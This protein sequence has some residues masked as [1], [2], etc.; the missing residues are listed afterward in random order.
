MSESLGPGTQRTGPFGKW[1]R[2][3]RKT[4]LETKKILPSLC[5]TVAG[6]EQSTS[7]QSLAAVASML[8]SFSFLPSSPTVATTL[9]NLGALYRKQMK[10]EA[11]ET[12]EDCALRARKEVGH[13]V[14]S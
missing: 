6:I 13:D 10:F 5:S 3:G 7:G 12:L 8:D 1:L 4:G 9:K 11:A 14:L 2:R